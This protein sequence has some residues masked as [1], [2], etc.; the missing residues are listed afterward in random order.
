M[1]DKELGRVRSKGDLKI[2]NFF[3]CVIRDIF[4]FQRSCLAPVILLLGLFDVI[5]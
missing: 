5:L 1:K 4:E 2:L 3:A